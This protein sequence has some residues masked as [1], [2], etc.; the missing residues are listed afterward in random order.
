MDLTATD[1]S[2]PVADFGFP[3]TRVY[4]QV[5]TTPAGGPVHLCSFGFVVTLPASLQFTGVVSQWDPA[6][7]SVTG[8][9]LYTSE[10]LSDS[11]GGTV[12]VSV[13]I[14]APLILSPSTQYVLFFHAILGTGAG[15][16]QYFSD[17]SVY[18]GGDFF[19]L[20]GPPADF[21]GPWS[22][23]GTPL[24]FQVNSA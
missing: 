7:S 18:T 1:G 22:D 19:Y 17:P 8:P 5:I 21:S 11:S 13:D 9:I 3:D 20:N 15:T 24:Q 4:G 23:W 10:P 14:P 2:Q 12:L 6:T 16:F